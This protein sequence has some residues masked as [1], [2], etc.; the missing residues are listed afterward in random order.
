MMP[1]NNPTAASATLG[2]E[3]ELGA[4]GGS[5]SLVKELVMPVVLVAFAVYLIVGIV[6]MRVPE[7]TAF[8]G[9][10][11]FPALI[12]A[13]LVL[14]AVLMTVG[15][16]RA[17]AAAR[18]TAEGA[19]LPPLTTEE[20]EVLAETGAGAGGTAAAGAGDAGG[21][22]PAKRVG[23]DWASLAWIVGGFLG[24]ALT[25][26]WLGWIIGAALL[27]WCVARG[28]SSR[29]ALFDLVVGLTASSITYIAFDMLLG[30]SFPSGVLGWG[31]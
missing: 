22:A 25:L 4:E 27:F 30:L 17:R 13:G 16:L 24:F 31:F 9:P 12:A 19:P 7:G 3:I 11:F 26:Q 15:A 2:E 20:L 6:T 8:P 14:F 18:G 29:R 21:S 23:I 5:G 28:F 1:S 10:Q